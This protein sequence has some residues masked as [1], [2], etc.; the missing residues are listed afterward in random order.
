MQ[1]GTLNWPPRAL[2][3][4]H[5]IKRTALQTVLL[6]CPHVHRPTGS[7]VY[8]GE[9]INS[10]AG[11]HWQAFAR[12]DYFDEHGIFYNSVVSGP[13][14]ITLLTV[15]VRAGWAAAAAATVLSCSR[16][17]PSTGSDRRGEGHI[18]VITLLCEDDAC[19]ALDATRCRRPVAPDTSS[20]CRCSTC[21]KPPASWCR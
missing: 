4:S 9:N 13:A 14:I 3:H 11:Q 2:G 5:L 19:A 6:P 12:Q 17:S 8:F 21:C 15:L 18:Q 1:R 20:R 16:Q 10:V 7:L